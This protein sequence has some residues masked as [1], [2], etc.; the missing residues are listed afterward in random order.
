MKH[1]V[2]VTVIKKE[3]YEDLQEKYLANPKAGPCDRFEV[4]EE[5][6]FDGFG[7]PPEFWTKNG[8]PR[9]TEVWD[10][11]SR[12]VYAALQ[13]GSIM[14]GWTND[15]KMMIACCNYGTRP[16]VFKIERMDVEE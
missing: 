5:F 7:G 6:I 10:C 14:E 11:I 2:K 15:E 9:C 8:K 13:G 12:Y 16:V 4:G 1:K 3:C